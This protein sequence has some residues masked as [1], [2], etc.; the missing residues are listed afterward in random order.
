MGG[1]IGVGLGATNTSFKSGG[2]NGQHG[3][4][5]S[6]QNS[7]PKT[8]IGYNNVKS[9]GGTGGQASIGGVGQGMSY[10][11]KYNSANSMQTTTVSEP[12]QDLDLR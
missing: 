7:R 6:Q 4:G 8:S 10:L 11:D 5:P 2:A 12:S 1:G 9:S 3:G